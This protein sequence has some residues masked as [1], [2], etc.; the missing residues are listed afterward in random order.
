MAR[1]RFWM[2]LIAGDRR[3][4]DKAKTLFLQTM[5][6]A[7]RADRP[8][9]VADCKYCLAVITY[10]V[11]HNPEIALQYVEEALA[12]YDRLGIQATK[13]RSLA[14]EIAMAMKDSGGSHMT[15]QQNEIVSPT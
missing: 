4:S 3:Q 15:L 7:V 10:R 11:D 2:G 12:V 9:L 13:A 8:D 1:A 6:E 14:D 5:E